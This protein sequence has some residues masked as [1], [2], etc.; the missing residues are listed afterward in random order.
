MSDVEIRNEPAAEPRRRWGS[1]WLGR[2]RTLRLPISA[3]SAR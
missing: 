3:A 1:G 2:L